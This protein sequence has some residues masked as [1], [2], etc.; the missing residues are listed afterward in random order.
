MQFVQPGSQGFD[1]LSNDQP[2]AQA[3]VQATTHPS[4]QQPLSTPGY[5]M[6]SSQHV[7]TA[8]SSSY[9]GQLTNRTFGAQATAVSGA[10][11]GWGEASALAY[12]PVLGPAGIEARSWTPKLLQPTP[13]VPSKRPTQ[14][15]LADCVLCS[16]TRNIYTRNASSSRLT[17]T[18]TNN[19]HQQ[20]LC[21][22]MTGI[23]S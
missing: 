3:Y 7:H 8:P 15:G 17:C 2:L 14:H 9:P 1:Q 22:D 10:T 20:R 12:N 5:D 21:P 16:I 13:P 4:Y 18:N 6:Y 19:Q 23:P 11:A